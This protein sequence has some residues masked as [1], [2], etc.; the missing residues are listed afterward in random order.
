MFGRVWRFDTFDIRVSRTEQFFEQWGLV[1]TVEGA[2]HLGF[3]GYAKV[4]LALRAPSVGMIPCSWIELGEIPLAPDT[5]AALANGYQCWSYSPILGKNDTLPPENNPLQETFGDFDLFRYQNEHGKFHSWSFT[6]TQLA[7]RENGEVRANPFFAALDEDMGM[8]AFKVDLHR[9][10]IT[11]CY[12]I[13]GLS[14]GK[15]Y[16]AKDAVIGA[17]L[18]ALPEAS[19]HLS[20]SAAASH[21]MAALRKQERVPRAETSK[22]HPAPLLG[23]TSWYYRYSNIDAEWIIKNLHGYR[24]LPGWTV[25]QMDD[26]YQAKIGDWLEPAST[27]P[28]G[29]AP[30][31]KAVTDAGKVPGIWWAPFV[32]IWN[33]KIVEKNPDWLLR[34]EQGNLVL[35]G[36]FPHWGGKFYALDLERGDVQQYLSACVKEFAEMGIKFIKA[37]FLYAAARVAAGGMTR[38][39]RGARAHQFLFDLCLA[40]GIRFLSCGATLGAAFGRCDYSRIGPD[41]LPDWE[42]PEILHFTSR[43]KVS[44]RGSIVNA[45]TRAFLNGVAFGNDPDVVILRDQSNALIEDQRRL[46]FEVNTAFGSLVFSSDEPSELGE[47]QRSLMDGAV[48]ANA[49]AVDR[50]MVTSPEQN[51]CVITDRAEMQIHANK[52][53]KFTRRNLANGSHR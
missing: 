37:D 31:V 53:A 35:C 36:D 50:L 28:E 14:C 11:I 47:W 9:R 3:P 52:L 8:T 32:A 44:T 29:V 20:L 24:R 49:G 18:V 41:V 19:R 25:F 46:L 5:V 13:G 4:S 43:E 12:H 10:V 22:N 39:M 26:G 48:A 17:W 40:N 6:Y 33:A 16:L 15:E 38:A 51:Y 23:Y 2:D 27:F 30:V 34:D 7:T 45:I 42:N 21:W 1:A